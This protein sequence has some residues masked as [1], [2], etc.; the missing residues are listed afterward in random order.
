VANRKISVLAGNQ[1]DSIYYLY[2]VLFATAFV[3]WLFEFYALLNKVDECEIFSEY[4]KKRSR[5][6]KIAK[7]YREEK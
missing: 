5:D 4:C 3:R 1:I 6:K 7:S 2:I